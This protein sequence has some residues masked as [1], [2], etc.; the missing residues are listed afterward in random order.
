MDN[1]LK[2]ESLSIFE[3]SGSC[4]RQLKIMRQKKKKEKDNRTDLY[5]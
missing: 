1:W 3:I 2:S 4:P 5:R